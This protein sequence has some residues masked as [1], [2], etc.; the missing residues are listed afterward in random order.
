[1]K[2]GS[3]NGVINKLDLCKPEV[4][5]SQGF[6]RIPRDVNPDSLAQKFFQGDP[7]GRGNL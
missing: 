2:R 7:S 3:C 6:T 4:L 1:M 5:L